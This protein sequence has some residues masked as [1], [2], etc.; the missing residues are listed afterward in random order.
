[1]PE[2]LRF[3]MILPNGQP[4]RWDMGPEFRWDGNVPEFLTNPHIHMPSDNLISAEMTAAAVTAVNDAI[5]TI[6]TN[7]PF[8]VSLTNAERRSKAK[9]G[10]GRVAL[11]EDAYPL[12]AQ[13][14]ALLPM[15]IVLAEVTKDR[16]LR[17]QLDSIRLSLN[18]LCS[19][20]DDTE[21]V[22]GH[23]MFKAYLAFYS[24]AQQAAARGVAGAQTVVDTLAP[25]FA[26]PSRTP[27]TPTPPVNP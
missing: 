20:V 5:A 10:D 22:L 21:L 13:N 14:P 8:L 19:E 25:Y 9:L 11:D 3:D 24:N 15:F 2:P 6:R 27:A 23:E 26:R 1:M 18:S 7:L 4:L 12:M 16:A 17:S